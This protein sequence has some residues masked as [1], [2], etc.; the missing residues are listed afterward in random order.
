MYIV[1]PLLA[2]VVESY[3]AIKKYG[4]STGAI[5]A[6]LT[7]LLINLYG[8]VLPGWGAPGGQAACVTRPSQGAAALSGWPGAPAGARPSGG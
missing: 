1:S 4:K 6:L 5:S 3:I 2:G 7:F 8:W